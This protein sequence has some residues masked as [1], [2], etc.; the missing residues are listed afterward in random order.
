MKHRKK[1]IAL[2]ILIPLIMFIAVLL[3]G[4]TSNFM[5]IVTFTLVV[6]WAL[7]YLALIL[8][9]LAILNNSHRKLSLIINIFNILL[10]L[11]LITFVICIMEKA[12]IL[13]LIEYIIILAMSIL[14]TVMIIKDIQLNPDPEIEEINKIKSQNNGIIK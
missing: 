4:L 7:P 14:N 1:L 2:N 13:I 5:N 3:T 10:T 11:V 6:G 8:T 9:G 12:L